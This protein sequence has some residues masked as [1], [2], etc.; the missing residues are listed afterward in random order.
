MDDRGDRCVEGMVEAVGEAKVFW[1]AWA[2]AGRVDPPPPPTRERSVWVDVYA[3]GETR[4]GD[5]FSEFPHPEFMQEQFE[6]SSTNLKIYCTITE[7][8]NQAPP[9]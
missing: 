1:G 3:T 8:H 7:A 2:V 9:R 6:I 5:D 4:P